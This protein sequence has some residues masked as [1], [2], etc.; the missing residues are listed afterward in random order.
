MKGAT[1]SNYRLRSTLVTPPP[2][3][4]PPTQAEVSGLIQELEELPILIE[5]EPPVQQPLAQQPPIQQPPIQQPPLQQPPVHQPEIMAHLNLIKFQDERTELPVIWWSLFESYRQCL[6]MNEDRAIGS[7]PFHL[8][9]QANLWF[10]TLSN[11]TKASLDAIKTAFL[12]R[13]QDNNSDNNI[14]NIRQHEHESG[15]DFFYRVQKMSLGVSTVNELGMV[16]LTINGLNDSLKPHVIGA[17]PSTWKELKDAIETATRIAECSFKVQPVQNVTDICDKISQTILTNIDSKMKQLDQVFAINA[18][19]TSNP[20]NMLQKK[21]YNNRFKQ[22]SMA[23]TSTTTVA[24]TTTPVST[25][26]TVATT[27]MATTTTS[28]TVA[29]TTVA[30]TTTTTMASTTTTVETT[31]PTKPTMVWTHFKHR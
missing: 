26:T 18:A 30:T 2:P 31:S 29:T 10:H 15:S 22:C 4:P 16:K 8:T 5:Q 14:V 13:F 23:A 20:N 12:E 11:E 27:T 28:T 3:P 17:K 9:G 24:T 19:A 25:T 7:L 21:K 1:P 6:G